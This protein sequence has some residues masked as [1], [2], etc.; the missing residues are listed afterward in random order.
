MHL[1]EVELREVSRRTARRTRPTT[2]ARLKLGHFVY[3]LVA[4]T[5]IIAVDINRAGLAY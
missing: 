1:A 2:D 4:L 3:N 5:Q